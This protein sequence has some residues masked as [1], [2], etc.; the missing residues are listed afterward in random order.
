MSG[1][2]AAIAVAALAL[3]SVGPSPAPQAAPQR[4]E[5]AP[6]GLWSTDFG[7]DQVVAD[8]GRWQLDQNDFCVANDA[9]NGLEI[10]VKFQASKE[11]KIS[12]VR[13]YRVDRA[14][15]RGSLWDADGNLLADRIDPTTYTEY[16]GEAV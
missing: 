5:P 9:R 10:G 3:G 6:T 13:I 16:L 1:I 4:A 12:G 8:C 7:A 2:A 15:V 14:T 11:L